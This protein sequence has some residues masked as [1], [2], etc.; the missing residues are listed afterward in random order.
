M[1][2]PAVTIS[3]RM[4][5]KC[6]KTLKNSKPGNSYLNI[7][8]PIISS[9][10]QKTFRDSLRLFFLTLSLLPFSSSSSPSSPFSLPFSHP[11]PNK[12]C[13]SHCPVPANS[14]PIPLG[15][16]PWEGSSTV[17]LSLFSRDNLSKQL[18]FF[19]RESGR[20][21]GWSSP[22]KHTLI[23]IISSHKTY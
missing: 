18:Q 3:T 22:A 19:L 15:L 4:S 16:P 2:R 17:V 23:I 21:K 11:V 9:L 10:Y 6:R 7:L 5:V 14:F 1:V 20:L 8:P 13:S 12:I